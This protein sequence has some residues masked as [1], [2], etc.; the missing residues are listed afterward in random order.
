MVVGIKNTFL[1]KPHL[2]LGSF[3][4]VKTRYQTQIRFFVES[5]DSTKDFF[6]K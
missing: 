2:E 6:V 4:E 1:D 3:F 5:V